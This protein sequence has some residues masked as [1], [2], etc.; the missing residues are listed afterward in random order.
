MMFLNKNNIIIKI[1]L[2]IIVLILVIT[3]IEH[4]F[5]NNKDNKEYIVAV[6]KQKI[7]RD[8]V[9]NV[10]IGE[11]ERQKQILGENFFIY[12]KDYEKQLYQAILSQLID[13]VLIEQYVKKINV[14]INDNHIKRIVFSQPAFLTNG[15]FDN[16][17][18][19]TILRSTGLTVNKYVDEIRK[20]LSVQKFLTTLTDTEFSLNNEIKSFFD[21]FAQRRII[22]DSI[23]K[24]D[25][26]INIQQVNEEEIKKYYQENKN[27]FIEK[28]QI[29][30]KYFKIDAKDSKK[31]KIDE[32]EIKNWYQQNKQKFTKNQ[33]NHYKL[34]QT[35]TE[36]EAQEILRKLNS[37]ITF[38]KIVQETD[39]LINYGDIGWMESSEIPDELKEAKILI[40]KYQFSSII[41]TSL[42]FIIL[43]IDDVKPHYIQSL[44][45]VEQIIIEEIQK[46]KQLK[47]Y[48]IIY[49]KL[50]NLKEFDE[51][52][53][54]KIKKI[55]GSN[56]EQ[57]KQFDSDNFPDEINISSLK[58][59][60]FNKIKS[61]NINNTNLSTINIVD[62]NGSSAFVFYIKDYV[63]I[64]LK[65]LEEVKAIIIDQIKVEKS[66]IQAKVNA[67]KIV[68]E[69][70]SGKTTNDLK[71]QEKKIY[72]RDNDQ[73]NIVKDVFN[74]PIPKKNM[75]SYGLTED[76]QGNPI[77]L[78]LSDVFYYPLSFQQRKSI[79]FNVVQNSINTS[80]LF[81][82]EDLRDKANIEYFKQEEN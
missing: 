16:E 47:A 34:I 59:I 41:K 13:E 80:F 64:Y 54:N 38:D 18:Y 71:F 15:K 44:N 61:F 20:R 8:S 21:L 67:Y 2:A 5:F 40:N 45:E 75:I 32:I 35:N 37:G 58:N 28:D 17:K 73:N 6:N 76:D 82:M 72:S 9:D 51:E 22:N 12:N 42:G 68:S 7:V 11:K 10:F 30:V 60:V 1:V 26:F 14:K 36:K 81:L 3:G 78:A 55:S 43:Y 48:K 56:N 70:K 39:H 23:I 46:E 79:L 57:I 4:F 77:I 24:Y 63:P 69:L 52:G 27:N 49:N 29:T 65:R 25:D 62:I 74:L 19:L 53:F 31:E 33:I 66:K 50:I